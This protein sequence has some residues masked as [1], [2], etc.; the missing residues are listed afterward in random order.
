MK[1]YQVRIP[2]DVEL[3]LCHLHPALKK[4]IRY[5]LEEL[6]QDP[7]LGKPLK[8]KLKGFHSYRVTQYRIIYEIRFKEVLVDIVDVGERKTIY[9][10]VETLLKEPS[11]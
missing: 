6:E 4:K 3:I 11:S 7:Y 8:E 5:A 2:P 1:K 9:T 10:R